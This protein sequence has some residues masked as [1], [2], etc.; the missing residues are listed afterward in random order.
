MI[1]ILKMD[2]GVELE[3]DTD[4]LS[5]GGPLTTNVYPLT[6]KYM[7][8]DKTEKG[9]LMA[10]G[11]FETETGRSVRFSECL[12]SKKS[13]TF[14]TTYTDKRSGKEKPLP[15][16]TKLLHLAHAMG[17]Q[18]KDLSGLTAEPKILKLYDYDAKKELPQEKKVITDFTGK[19]IQAAIY[20]QVET[21]MAKD[22]NGNYTVPTAEERTLNT[23]EK[24]FTA[25]GRT[26]EEVASGDEASFKELWLTAHKDKVRDKRAKNAPKAG[27]P[28]A[29]GAATSPAPTLKFDD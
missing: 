9:A 6:A 16:Y 28:I 8:L 17:I 5:T 19:A 11:E 27:A 15:G 26:I 22:G 7:Y 18:V 25:D 12:G 20:N 1:D 2:A 14:K 21:K 23:F 4:V 24:W 3:K 10:Y 13:G 29:G